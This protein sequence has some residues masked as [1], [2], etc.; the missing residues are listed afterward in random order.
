MDYFRLLVE[1]VGGLTAI[2]IFTKPIRKMVRE[3]TKRIELMEEGIQSILHDRIYQ[4]CH[5]FISRGWV[6]ISDL[7]NLE[8]LYEPYR[9]MG[10]N[11][12]A[13]ELHERVLDLEIREDVIKNEH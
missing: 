13:K 9:Q 10:G 12:T 5:F 4:A 3:Q 7:K 1:I 6:C 11:G 2:W 8:H